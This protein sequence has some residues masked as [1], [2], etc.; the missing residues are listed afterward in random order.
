MDVDETI[1]P[2]RPGDAGSAGTGPGRSG[3]APLLLLRGLYGACAALLGLLPWLVTGMR[4]PLQ[5]LWGRVVAPDRMPRALLP[6][7]QYAVALILGLVVGGWALAGALE[8]F[9]AGRDG[10]T[11]FRWR[12]VLALGAGVLAVDCAAA[13][14]ALPVAASGLAPGSESTIYLVGLV[15]VVAGSVVVGMGV[16]LLIARGRVPVAT[17]AMTVGAVAAGQWFGGFIH[18]VGPIQSWSPVAAV[19]Y[20]P[21]IWAPSVITGLAIAWGLST[22]STAAR[23]RS[24][25]A[26]AGPFLVASAGRIAG[27]AVSLGILWVLPA[28]LEVVQGAVGSRVL[29]RMPDELVRFAQDSFSL[30]LSAPATLASVT[31][32]AAIGAVGA[33]IAGLGRHGHRPGR[34]LQG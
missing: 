16:F 15:A 7:S 22:P 26:G 8:R 5:N 31:L 6:L 27:G 10:M 34:P 23:R 28:A 20:Y 4:L 33:V 25:S 13:G 17:A 21:S 14:Q 24:G 30:H 11:G 2:V 19:F 18:V 9:G 3:Q 1:T 12:R 32:A 29:L